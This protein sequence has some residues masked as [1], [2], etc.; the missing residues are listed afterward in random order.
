MSAPTIWI[1]LVTAAMLTGMSV[2]GILVVKQRAE[3]L[4]A[5][6]AIL[7]LAA[8]GNLMVEVTRVYGRFDAALYSLAF[9]IAGAGAGYALASSLLGS[10]ARVPAAPKPPRPPETARGPA[11]IIVACH[12]PETYSPFATAS[13]L[14]ALEEDGLFVS[15]SGTLPFLFFAQ[16]ARY[17]AIG[18]TS[19]SR[20]QLAA[21]AEKTEHSLPDT[22]DVTV[23]W[24]DCTGK[25]RLATRVSD[26]VSAGHS[27][28]VVVEL[29]VGRSLA[30]SAAEQEV[31]VM[32][33]D[34]VGV[35]VH[36]S[37][38][39]GESDRI[40]SAL[41]RRTTSA[42]PSAITSGVVLVGHAQPDAQ[43]RIDPAFDEQE[44]VFLNRMRLMIVE[45]GVPAQNVR[46][47]WAEWRNPDVTSS[48]RHL[49]ALGCNRIVVVPATYPLDSIAT[50]LD[51]ELAARQSRIDDSVVVVTMPSWQDDEQVVA[52]V[53]ERILQ[54]LRSTD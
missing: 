45:A 13:M 15:S 37:G 41:S 33:L 10:M 23:Y 26:A 17:R 29:G 34:R 42:T 4:F 40:I 36:Y 16:K 21:L 50:R 48:V 44:T 1:G 3:P 32:K 24:A 20:R 12:E 43:S 6:F 27:K 49:A 2:V 11:A 9:L 35:E 28:V 30:L 5:L 22:E 38:P 46:I 31:D 53:R 39:V 54:E 52:E 18:G 25:E 19:P 8:V 51:L 14:R 47:A 7:S